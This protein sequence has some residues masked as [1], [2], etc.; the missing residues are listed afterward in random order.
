MPDVLTAGGIW[1]DPRPTQRVKNPALLRE[2]HLLWREC[3]LCHETW[4]LSLH[5]VSKHPR[6]D[7]RGNLVMLCGDGVRG[8][9][10]KIEAHDATTLR[11]LGRHILDERPDTIAYLHEKMGMIAAHEWM[12]R[13]LLV[14]EKGVS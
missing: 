11:A 14:E 5:H 4:P 1:D 9:H 3:A 12:R 2:L 7:V 6:D 8:C 10:G 13:H